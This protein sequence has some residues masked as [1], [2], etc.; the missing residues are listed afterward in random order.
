M[1]KTSY[2]PDDVAIGARLRAIRQ[3]RHQTQESLADAAG[4]TFQQIQKYEKGANRI[5]AGRLACFARLLQVEAGAFF[6]DVTG[7]GAATAM[8]RF[9]AEAI[10]L[11]RPSAGEITN[12]SRCG[13]MRTGSRKK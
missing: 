1:P 12:P 8:P 10:W 4:V 6:V 3:Q 9:S 2:N 11:T 13:T 7:D 5:G